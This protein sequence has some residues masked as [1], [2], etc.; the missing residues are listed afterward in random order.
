MDASSSARALEV[1][2]SKRRSSAATRDWM[3]SSRSL[4]RV[5]SVSGLAWRASMSCWE[6]RTGVS[7]GGWVSD[8]GGCVSGGKR[9]YLVNTCWVSD[10]A[11]LEEPEPIV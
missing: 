4:A 3:C 7:L 9:G 11:G 5:L 10:G 2:V 8:W 1:S 6:K